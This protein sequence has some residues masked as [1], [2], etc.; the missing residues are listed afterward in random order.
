MFISGKSKAKTT[1]NKT[2]KKT[3][4]DKKSKLRTLISSV[5]QF[6]FLFQIK[7]QHQ[8]AA[9][10]DECFIQLA[11]YLFHTFVHQTWTRDSCSQVLLQ[12]LSDENARHCPFPHSGGLHVPH[13]LSGNLCI[14]DVAFYLADK[15]PLCTCIFLSR[16]KW[17]GCLLR[18]YL[19]C[20]IMQLHI[21][22]YLAAAVGACWKAA[23]SP[24]GPCFSK[25][26]SAGDAF[27]PGGNNNLHGNERTGRP[28]LNATHKCGYAKTEL[29]PSSWM[30]P[31][32][33]PQFL[34]LQQLPRCGVVKKKQTSKR[35][36]QLRLN[37]VP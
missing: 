18:H 4:P 1:L 10:T 17:W 15:G 20:L 22:V 27:D 28:D 23:G 29:L 32:S 26:T 8:I 6:L 11:P 35:S 9:H 19:C 3:K 5:L 7:N 37:R 36:S 33:L 16:N 2:N 31:S 24:R 14:K 34:F 25:F 13:L 12:A 21:K 30:P